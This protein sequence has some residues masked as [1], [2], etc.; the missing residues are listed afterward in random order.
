MSTCL[1]WNA[2]IPEVCKF[3]GNYKTKFF[4]F[5]LMFVAH[6]TLGQGVGIND[7][8]KLNWPSW[9]STVYHNGQFKPTTSILFLD[10]DTFFFRHRDDLKLFQV[11]FCLNAFQWH[12]GHCSF[13][14][15]LGKRETV[16]ALFIILLWKQK[17][18][19]DVWHWRSISAPANGAW[20]CPPHKAP[21]RANEMTSVHH[22]AWYLV[23]SWHMLAD[24]NQFN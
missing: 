21:V 24:L 6:R 19:I 8:L 22:T 14:L 2:Y 15:N 23:G 11:Q 5:G 10:L 4:Y 1:F 3:W 7:F 16:V 17:V 9:W 12:L 13:Q 20:W 18:D